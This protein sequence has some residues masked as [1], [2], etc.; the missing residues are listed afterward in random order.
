MYRSWEDRLSVHNVLLVV[1]LTAVAVTAVAAAVAV[2][3]KERVER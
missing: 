2:S 1:A 3:E